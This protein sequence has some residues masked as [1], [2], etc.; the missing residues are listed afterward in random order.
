MRKNKYFDS[1][2]VYTFS[3]LQHLREEM[4]ELEVVCVFLHDL[5]AE[6]VYFQGGNLLFHFALNRRICY[7]RSKCFLYL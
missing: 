3:D 5:K 7:Q 6:S 4:V 1:C 2:F